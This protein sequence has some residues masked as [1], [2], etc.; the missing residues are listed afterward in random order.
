[1]LPFQATVTTVSCMRITC[2]GSHTDSTGFLY[3]PAEDGLRHENQMKQLLPEALTA[4]LDAAKSYAQVTI[5]ILIPHWP[6]GLVSAV[7]MIL[8]CPC[9]FP[10]EGGGNHGLIGGRRE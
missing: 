7:G 9:A 8:F 10:S 5:E 2:F 1:M 3:S 4:L 6:W